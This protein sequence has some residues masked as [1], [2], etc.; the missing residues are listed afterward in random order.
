MQVPFGR[1][2]RGQ[3]GDRRPV[4]TQSSSSAA[5]YECRKLR[6]WHFLPSSFSGL[7]ISIRHEI[8]ILGGGFKIFSPLPGEDFHF[9]YIIFFRWVETT[10]QDLIIHQ[11]QCFYAKIQPRVYFFQ[12]LE[13]ELG[14]TNLALLMDRLE[15]NPSISNHP[16]WDQRC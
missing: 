3:R 1:L 12:K 6:G 9:D 15:T 7:F 14:S 11:N 5:G 10:N 2:G 8:K 4:V 13:G 16:F